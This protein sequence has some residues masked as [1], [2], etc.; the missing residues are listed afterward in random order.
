M[1]KLHR[2]G[3]GHL[4]YRVIKWSALT[5]GGMVVIASVFIGSSSRALAQSSGCGSASLTVMQDGAT[6]L[7]L[8]K[9]EGRRVP[10]DLEKEYQ[11][12]VSDA[13][14]SGKLRLILQFAKPFN[15]TLREEELEFSNVQPDRS[16]PLKVIPGNVMG[17]LRHF[18]GLAQVAIAVETEN[19]SNGEA[20]RSWFEAQVGDGSLDGPVPI[21]TAVCAGAGVLGSAAAAARFPAK[22]KI[23]CKI[24]LIF[25]RGAHILE[26]HWCPTLRSSICTTLTGIAIA[27]ALQENA[28]AALTT[29][30]FWTLVGAGAAAGPL[31]S[32]DWSSLLKSLKK[33]EPEKA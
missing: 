15:I 2:S 26:M 10:V 33:P 19:T 32:V 23:R 27:A 4:I 9:D 31:I 29:A 22:Q 11:V 18:R 20:C 17:L 12:V 21:A 16:Y 8:P 28:I 6:L 25:R 7:E 30:N 24:K 14:I 13:P 3:R 5:L 1:S